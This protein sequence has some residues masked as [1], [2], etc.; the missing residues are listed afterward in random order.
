M[1][2]VEICEMA[3]QLELIMN[4]Y[5]GYQDPYG[6]GVGGFKRIEFKRG[7]IVKYNFMNSDLF[8]EFDA[9]LVFTGVTRNSKK[10]LKDVTANIQK[11]RPLLE[12]VE[13]AHDA[14]YKKNYDDFLNLMNESWILKKNTSDTILKN[15]WIREMDEE[16]IENKSVI[17]HKLCGA[18]NGGFFLTFS[19]KGQLNIPF[20]CVKIDVE[21]KGV[22]G[23][24]L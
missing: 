4:P 23:K 5:C 2:D 22:T 24:E 3:Y 19:K 17:A 12:T 16:L 13:V 15:S 21:T 7:G 18:G 9:H 1:T 20:D 10:V 8:R 11:S 14:F 6:C